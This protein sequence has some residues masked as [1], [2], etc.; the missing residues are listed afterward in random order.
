MRGYFV[1]KYE[2]LYYENVELNLH[3]R[4]G[5][6]RV[7]E[8]TLV[9]NGVESKDYLYLF[10]SLQNTKLGFINR[11][12]NTRLIHHR[13]KKLGGKVKWRNATKDILR[14]RLMY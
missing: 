8:Y 10:S 6:G 14:N 13:I 1:K 4:I 12:I 5:N 9:V 7:E 2:M 3:I 11:F